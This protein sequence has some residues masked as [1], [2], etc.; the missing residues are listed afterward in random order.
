[1]LDME[2]DLACVRL[3]SLI[4]NPYAVARREN[5]ERDLARAWREMRRRK[6]ARR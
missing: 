3:R 1:M 6:G 4:M 2:L 5:H